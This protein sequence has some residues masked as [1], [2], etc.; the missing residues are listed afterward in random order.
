[1]QQDFLGEAEFLDVTLCAQARIKR[2]LQVENR[3]PTEKE[4]YLLKK[5]ERDL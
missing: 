5:Y 4:A 1:L 3:H 2:M